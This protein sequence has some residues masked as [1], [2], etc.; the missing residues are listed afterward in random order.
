MPNGTRRSGRPSSSARCGRRRCLLNDAVYVVGEL[1]EVTALARDDG[2]ASLDLREGNPVDEITISGHAGLLLDDGMRLYVGFTDGAVTALNPADGRVQWELETAL[3][4][5]RRPGNV[6]QFLDV[7]TTPSC[8]FAER[9]SSRRS[10]Q[11]STRST[12]STARSIWRDATFQGVTGPRSGGTH[13]GH[14]FGPP[15]RSH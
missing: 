2:S 3:D 9:S 8:S 14:L 10:R 6:P 5:E 1:D 7:D 15:G 4:V 13:A 12:R 11:G